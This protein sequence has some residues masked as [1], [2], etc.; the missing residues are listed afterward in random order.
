MLT[1]LCLHFSGVAR[2]T[3]VIV[4]Q[5]GGSRKLFCGS[6]GVRLAKLVLMFEHFS[7]LDRWSL[8]SFAYKTRN[9]G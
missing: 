3:A 6:V 9:T 5:A 1:A 7:A 2:G 4:Y 8:G